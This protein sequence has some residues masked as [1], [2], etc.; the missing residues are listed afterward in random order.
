M[1]KTVRKVVACCL[2]EISSDGMPVT[3]KQQCK[4][5]LLLSSFENRQYFRCSV[6]RSTWHH[7]RSTI[8]LFLHPGQVARW[9]L[10][11]RSPSTPLKASVIS[12]IKCCQQVSHDCGYVLVISA[13]CNDTC[14]EM[15]QSLL[16]PVINHLLNRLWQMEFEQCRTS[17]LF[18][19]WW[20]AEI[21]NPCTYSV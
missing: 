13:F 4:M 18:K 14:L 15:N 20:K 12:N 21:L 17:F 2:A 11:T 8:H 6:Y 19:N 9:R 5:Y 1:L 3:R 10:R 16:L 7:F